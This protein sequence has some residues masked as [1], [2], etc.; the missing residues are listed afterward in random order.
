MGGGAWTDDAYTAKKSFLS[1]SGYSDS[2]THD[3]DV[4]SGKVSTALHPDMNPLNVKVR[5][6]RDSA[7]HPESNAVAV[8]FDVTGS[9]GSVPK[10]LQEKLPKLLATLLQRDCL[11][12]PQ[13]L[14]GAI[15][16]VTCDDVALQ[17]GQ[18]ESDI[19]I[20]DTLSKIFIEGG[21]GGQVYESYELAM[22]FMARHTSID[23]L[24]KR[25]KK[26]YLFIIGDECARNVSK[27]AV[28]EVIGDTLQSN[29]P[30]KEV[31]EEVL[32]KYELYYIIPNQT[33]YFNDNRVNKFWKDLLG[34]RFIKLDNPNLVCECIA[35]LIAA[36]EGQDVVKTAKS[37]GLSDSDTS[38][39]SRA[40]AN[41]SPTPSKMLG[42]VVG[43]LNTSVLDIG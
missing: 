35:T 39:I 10:T 11:P 15:G 17:V 1:A 3:K 19:R 24:E 38:V 12:H 7:E 42:K 4:K 33:S 18:F 14:F 30:L 21:G 28:K 40:L 16:D 36:N 2:F 20:D 34:E 27:D 26:G 25:D 5:E 9:M 22:Y 8:F 41:V 37:M 32:E 31:I 13:I 6:S 43:N 29:I 23:C